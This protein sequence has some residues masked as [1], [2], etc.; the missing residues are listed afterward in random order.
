MSKRSDGQARGKY[1]LELKLGV[2]RLV[3]VI[4]MRTNMPHTFA[5]GDIVGQLMLAT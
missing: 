1:T 2:V 5:I 3:K 4:Q